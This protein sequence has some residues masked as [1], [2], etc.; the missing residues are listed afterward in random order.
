M[1]FVDSVL[2]ELESCCSKTGIP[3]WILIDEAHYFLRYA[4][5]CAA[6]FTGRAN[7]AFVTYRPSLVSTE[8]YATVTAHL[9]TRTSVE[10]ERYFITSLLQARGPRDIVPAEA[11]AELGMGR[12]GL[13]MEDATN[14]RWQVFMPSARVTA[15]AHHARKYAD[16]RLPEEKAFR[17][18]HTEGAPSAVAHN[19]IEFHSAVKTVPMASLR[20]HLTAGDLSRWAAGVLGDEL[21]ARALR[22]LERTVLAGA[23]PNRQEVLAHIEDHYLISSA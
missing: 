5:P 21:L 14:P 1:K 17:F 10:E 16:V 15:H 22:K 13:L 4:C 7:F 20:H 23:S 6:R 18:L 3:Q 2:C 8:I 9:V 11:L 12:A 19:I